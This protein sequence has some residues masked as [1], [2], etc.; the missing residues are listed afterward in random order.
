MIE[1]KLIEKKLLK[2]ILKKKYKNKNTNMKIL[3]STKSFLV[4]N[5][6]F[7]LI[8]SFILFLMYLKRKEKLENTKP[9]IKPKQKPET[10]L[11]CHILGLIRPRFGPTRHHFTAPH[12]ASHGGYRT[13][14]KIQGQLI[15][16]SSRT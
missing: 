5:W 6:Y 3:S 11:R 15:I 9:V 10:F 13:H 4:N 2:K 16:G 7:I 12:F 14:P 8:I 1:P